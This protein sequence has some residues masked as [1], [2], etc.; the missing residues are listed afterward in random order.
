M[1]LTPAELQQV[2]DQAIREY[3]YECCGVVLTREEPASRLF[4]PCRNQQNELH[5][6][7]KERHPRDATI[8]YSI[9][10]EDLKKIQQFLDIGY[11]IAVLYHSHVDVG[12]YFSE[13]DKKAAMLGSDFPPYPNA[14]YLVVSVRGKNTNPVHVDAAAA[15]RWSEAKRDFAGVDFELT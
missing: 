7:D 11:D 8:A 14:V 15:F 12:A 6:K 9:H 5:L 4:L 3:P 2:K 1:I 10:F 13:T